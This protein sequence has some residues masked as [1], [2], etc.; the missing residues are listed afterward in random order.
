MIIDV[1]T[2]L[3][4]RDQW[5]KVFVE[6]F[7]RGYTGYTGIDLEVTPEIHW[8]AVATVSRAI[9]FGINSIALGMHTPNDA[10]AAYAKAHPEKIIGFMSVDPN[11][12]DALKEIDRCVNDLGLKGIKMS[13]VYQHYDPNSAKAR[14]VH[15]RAE[16]LGLP[17]LTHA[18]YHV[19][20]NTPMEW[21][22]PLLYDPVAREFPN[23]KII[24]AHIGL[25][26]YTDAMVMIRKHPNVFADVSGGV[27]LRPWWGYQ[28]LAFCHENRVMHKLLFG[29][30]FP[31][32]TIEETIEALRT[33]NR[34]TEGAGMP[35]VPE[36]EI[37]A[38]IHRDSLSLLELD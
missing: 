25:P 8:E 11:D 17:I 36:D 1:H 7:D 20:A 10:I 38:L 34:F 21:A 22:N 19:I 12:P 31:I 27:P 3:S 13:P 37:E 29:S 30:D 24:L 32:A 33:A 18:A 15:R 28:A 14:Q 16:E 23:L 9:V 4:T 6:A 2:H 26:W 5:G 35:Q